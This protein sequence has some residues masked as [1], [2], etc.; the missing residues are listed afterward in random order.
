[1]ADLSTIELAELERIDA[2][3]AEGHD[4]TAIGRALHRSREWVTAVLIQMELADYEVSTNPVKRALFELHEQGDIRANGV[5]NGEVLWQ[6]NPG[7]GH[8]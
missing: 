7:G 6:I 2:L 4:C 1:M 3:R 5:R 8:G